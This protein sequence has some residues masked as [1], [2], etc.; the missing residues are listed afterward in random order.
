MIWKP[1][2]FS[3]GQKIAITYETGVRTIRQRT[4]EGIVVE[5]GPLYLKIKSPGTYMLVVVLYSQLKKVNFLQEIPDSPASCYA[6]AFMS[7]MDSTNAVAGWTTH[8][9]PL[10]DS[11]LLLRKR[12]VLDKATDLMPTSTSKKPLQIAR[13]CKDNKT[14]ELMPNYSNLEP[15][16]MWEEQQQKPNPSIRKT[17]DSS[18][19]LGVEY[20]FVFN[21]DENPTPLYVIESMVIHYGGSLNEKRYDQ[22]INRICF[23]ELGST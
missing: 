21:M 14:L 9:F 10:Y 11:F 20:A 1:S 8:W 19:P 3:A 2:D 6:Q 23:S 7:A 13:F 4:Y 12:K 18:E 5:A 16:L 17:Q 15:Y 22:L